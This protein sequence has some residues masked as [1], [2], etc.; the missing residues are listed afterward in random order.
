MKIKKHLLILLVF[1]GL[2]PSL[3]S[4]ESFYNKNSYRSLVADN[5]AHQ[6]GDNLTVL[7]VESTQAGT[8]AGT[9]SLSEFDSD[10]NISASAYDSVAQSKAGAKAG[11]GYGRDSKDS[12]NTSR[13]GHFSGQLAVRVVGID[14]HGM[15]QVVGEQSLIVNGEQQLVRIS[16]LVRVMDVRADN[17]VLSTRMSDAQIE[18]N[19]EGV[20]SDGQE[21]NIFSKFFNMFGL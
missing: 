20:V 14:E 5:R 2:L 7:I 11:L 3:V 10:F 18:F 6:V 21:P 17:T 19:G 4:A 16:G 15:M 9:G 13:E 12:A 8:R 1:G